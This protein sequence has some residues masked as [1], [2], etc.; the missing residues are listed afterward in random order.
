MLNARA[1]AFP[2]ITVISGGL[3]ELD[4]LPPL[5]IVVASVCGRV[6]TLVDRVTMR[7]KCRWIDYRWVEVVE[8]SF[9]DGGA[10]MV[11]FVDGRH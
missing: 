7:V 5:T 6:G 8:V 1:L 10:V 9:L 3:S 4:I 2:R 11:G